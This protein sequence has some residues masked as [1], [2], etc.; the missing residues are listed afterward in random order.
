MAQ[1]L[2]RYTLETSVVQFF[3]SFSFPWIFIPLSGSLDYFNENNNVVASSVFVWR[4]IC[5]TLTQSCYLR[6]RGRISS[7]AVCRVKGRSVD[8]LP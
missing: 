5:L 6:T 1:R 4:A 2:S 8:V 3:R 7:A